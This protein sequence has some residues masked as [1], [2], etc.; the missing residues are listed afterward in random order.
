MDISK[1]IPGLLLLKPFL[2]L[3]TNKLNMNGYL[4]SVII[5]LNLD[6]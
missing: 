6:T 2:G 4:N 5:V 3:G 1:V